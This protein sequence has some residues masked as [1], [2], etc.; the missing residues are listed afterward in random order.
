MDITGAYGQ[1]SSYHMPLQEGQTSKGEWKQR[2]DEIYFERF[3]KKNSGKFDQENEINFAVYS[4]KFL[5]KKKQEFDYGFRAGPDRKPPRTIQRFWQLYDQKRVN[6]EFPDET[7]EQ[8]WDRFQSEEIKESVPS[9]LP[10]FI[11]VEEDFQYLSEVELPEDQTGDLKLCKIT[12]FRDLSIDK[13]EPFKSHF[14]DLIS[15]TKDTRLENT[16]IYLS[17]DQEKLYYAW[18]IPSGKMEGVYLCKS[19]I[20]LISKNR[21]GELLSSNWNLDFDNYVFDLN[22]VETSFEPQ[23]AMLNLAIK[24][25]Q[26]LAVL[27]K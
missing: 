17:K 18:S 24:V 2:L 14:I 5:E 4:Q 3:N 22:Q 25:F 12:R 8:F 27:K 20:L 1:V 6:N 19:A 13:K 21:D 26:P 9:I 7:P 16:R 23:T 11:H 15:R 10:G